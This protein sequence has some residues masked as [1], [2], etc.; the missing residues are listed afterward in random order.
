MTD[1]RV[2][3]DELADRAI[4]RAVRDIMNAEPSAGFRHRV[5]RRLA[6]P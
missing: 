2:P 1:P 3:S 4:D 6:D 5:M